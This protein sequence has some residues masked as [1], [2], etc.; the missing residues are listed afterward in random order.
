MK[1]TT[2]LKPGYWSNGKLPAAVQVGINSVITGE[3]AFKRLGSQANPA[4]TIGENCTLNGV[5][6]SI[7]KEASIKIGDYCYFT[8]VILMCEST[9]EIGSYVVIGWNSSIAD[10]DFHPISPAKRIEDAIAV[11]PL[12]KNRNRPQIVSKPVVIE[13]D[14]WIGPNATVLKGVTIGSGAFIEAGSLVTRDVSP[15]SRV[16]GNPAK[17]IGKV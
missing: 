17:V 1:E 5:Q 10:S 9:F 11:S 7:G 14:V 16:A 15:R 6:F 4:L 12:G 3:N 13:D 2:D 8:N